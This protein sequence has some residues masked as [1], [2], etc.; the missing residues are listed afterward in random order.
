MINCL[1]KAT[2]KTAMGTVRL[3][4]RPGLWLTR[5]LVEAAF[6]PPEPERP[7]QRAATKAPGPT[8]SRSRSQ[9]RRKRASPGVPGRDVPPARPTEPHHMLNT[10]VGEPDPTEWPDP[11]DQRPDPRD[12]QPHEPIPIGDVPHTPTGARS[13]SAPHPNEDPEAVRSKPPERDT[14]DE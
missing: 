8:T 11:Y 14:L 6:K 2:A 13:T 3:L 12:P 5:T 7:P 4:S 1:V 9:A 10:P